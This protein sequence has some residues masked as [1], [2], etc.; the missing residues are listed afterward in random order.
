MAMAILVIWAALFTL[1]RRN[2][3]AIFWTSLMLM[4]AGP[5][6]EYW[7]IPGYWRPVYSVPMS[8]RSWNFG[9][10]DFLISF[11]I[12]GISAG[13]FESIALKKGL[14]EL[15]RLK[16]IVLLRIFSFCV[17]GFLLMVLLASVCKFSPIHALLLTVFIPSVLMLSTRPG[18]VPLVLPASLMAGV[19]FW[20][21]YIAFMLPF[22]PGLTQALWNSD[23][24][25]GTIAGIPIEEMLWASTTMLFA[26]P[27]YRFCSTTSFRQI[28]H[29][30]RGN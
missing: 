5:V 15:P 27:V 29:I 30:K 22:F 8:F 19:V 3:T 23:N 6:G 20:L 7:V 24:T 4:T 21:F 26:G 2:R 14:P 13:V 25:L 10:E 17:L 1:L 11:A 12:A 16:G 18:L 9:I 28:M